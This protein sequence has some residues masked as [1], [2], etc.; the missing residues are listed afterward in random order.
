MEAEKDLQKRK[1]NAWLDHVKKI[2]LKNPD[3]KYKEVL[4]IAKDTYKPTSNERKISTKYTNE[5]NSSDR[6]PKSKVDKR[7]IPV[8]AY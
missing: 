1:A 4:V 2:K 5:R 6:F 7:K 3:M 8:M